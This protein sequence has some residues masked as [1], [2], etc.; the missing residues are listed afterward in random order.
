MWSQADVNGDECLSRTEFTAMPAVDQLVQWYRSQMALWS[1]ANGIPPA[2]TPAVIQVKLSLPMT[3]LEFLAK[4]ALLLDAITA[5]AGSS[6]TSQDV[7]IKSVTEVLRRLLT[8][9]HLLASGVKLEAEIATNNAGVVMQV[10][11]PNRLT[12]ELASK[13]LPAPRGEMKRTTP[14]MQQREIGQRVQ[15]AQIK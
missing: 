11:N 9:R 6:V 7:S 1:A 4:E 10:L 3:R 8:A 14:E 13:R 12:Q 15:S 5:A 2:G